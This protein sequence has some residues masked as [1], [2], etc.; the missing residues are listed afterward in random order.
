MESKCRWNIRIGYKD[1]SSGF[2]DYNLVK[3]F[4]TE[5]VYTREEAERFAKDVEE[6]IYNGAHN[7]YY[8]DPARFIHVIEP[9]IGTEV[10][11]SENVVDIHTFNEYGRKVFRKIDRSSIV[12]DTNWIIFSSMDGVEYRLNSNKVLTI[13]I[14][15]HEEVTQ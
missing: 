2:P 3:D 15:K 7:A 1:D 13:R 4:D 6:D 14:V 8:R 5:N 10:D 12:Y 9:L 11:P